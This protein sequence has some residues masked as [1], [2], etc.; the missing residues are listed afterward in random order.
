MHKRFHISQFLLDVGSL[1]SSRFVALGIGILSSVVLARTLGPEDKGIVT[2]VLVIPSLVDS[3]ADLGLRQSTIYFMGKKIYDD[4]VILSTVVLLSL[5]TSGIGLLIALTSYWMLGYIASYGWTVVAVAL[6]MLPCAIMTSYS[7][8]VLLAK[9]QIKVVALASM[10]GRVS[11]LVL[12]VF[13]LYVASFGVIGAVSATALAAVV[14]AGYVIWAVARYG[15][16]R[17]AYI[18]GMPWSFIKLGFVYAIALFILG[19]GYRIDVVILEQLSTTSEIGIYSVGVGLA[20]MLW[21][22]PMALTTVNFARSAAAKDTMAYAK[23]T[24]MVM[25]ITLWFALIP[26]LFM[27]LL[28]PFLITLL[29]GEAY[30]DSGAVVRGILPGVWLALI[31]KI[32][33][34]DL[35][36]RGRPD[37][38]LWVYG[39][40]LLLNIAFNIWWIPLY[41]AQGSAWA[42]SVSYSF[43][44]IVFA[45]TYARMSD[46]RISDL[47]LLTA[48]DRIALRGLVTRTKRPRPESH[49]ARN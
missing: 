41:G 44:A 36:G 24:A 8:G 48:E 18:P 32:L 38:A 9:Q 28:A 3:F 35:A 11:Y 47:F 40:A 15:T 27:F 45:I 17:P 14:S 23:K 43:G 22:V 21:M 2:A 19:L 37:A 5:A 20:E 13:F 46:L 39:L 31:F 12:L 1:L 42:S 30:R 10:L 26:F 49:V 4:Q 34:S 7:N 16:L 25:R 6:V 29:Y 33:N